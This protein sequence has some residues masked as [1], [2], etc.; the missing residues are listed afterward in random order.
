MNDWMIHLALGVTAFLLGSI[1]FGLLIS[2]A[3]GVEDLQ[4][5]GSGN[6][7]ATNVSRVVGFWP[8]G[9]LTFALDAL[10]GVL[11][12]LPLSLGWIDESVF[13][14]SSVLLWSIGL[15]SVLGHCY[16]PWLRFQG[17]K[18]VATAF[19]VIFALAPWS[20]L[21]GGVVFGLAY[22]V[23]GV[24]AAGSL[25]GLLAAISVYRI[26]YPFDP[27][28]LI[29]AVMLLISLYRHDENLDRMLAASDGKA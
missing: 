14:A 6:I 11:L 18:G 17:G 9:F 8:A 22:L 2:K 10:K 3:Y 23:T 26:F 7:G 29:F 1:P 19:G 21:V 24:G 15:I 4:D 5:K 12:I 13:Q 28:M 27:S 16:S 25:M 20:G